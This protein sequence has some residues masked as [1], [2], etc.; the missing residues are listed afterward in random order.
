[1]EVGGGWGGR[2]AGVGEA[3]AG[4]V[5]GKQPVPPAGTDGLSEGGL[6]GAL[7]VGAFG[8]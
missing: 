4:E 3:G 8:D 1:M 6:V 7:A 2:W 5:S